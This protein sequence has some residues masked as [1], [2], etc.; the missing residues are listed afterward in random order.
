MIG[1][2]GALAVSNETAAQIGRDVLADGGNAVDAAVAVSFALGVVE[3]FHSGLG[4]GGF[5]VYFDAPSARVSALDL[6]GVAPAAA[7]ESMFVR[8]GAY[9]ADRAVIGHHSVVVPG[10]VAGLDLAHRR[11]GSRP[12]AELVE[13]AAR[14]AERGVAVTPIMAYKC[15]NDTTRRAL[16]AHPEGARLYLRDGRVPP[17]GTLLRNPDLAASCRLIGRQGADAF[18]RGEIASAIVAD[19]RRHDGPITADDLARYRPRDLPPLRGRYRD[20]ELFAMPPPS[21]GGTLVLQALGILEGFD[22]TA[23][24]RQAPETAHLLAETLKLAF[25]DRDYYLGD[26]DF[27]DPP[28]AG[29]L[30][31]R[32]LAARRSLIQPDRA[33]AAVGHGQPESAQTTSFSI[34]DRHGNLLALT[35][36]IGMNL[37]S[38]VVPPGTGIVLNHTM[39]D[40]SPGP[41][42]PTPFGWGA[43]SSRANAIA[44]GKA[45]ASSQAPTLVFRAGRPWFAV[46]AAG[47]SR[48]PTAVLQV[49]INAVDYDD[50]LQQAITA[51]RLH[52]QG[53]D[54]E[55]ERGWF[56]QVAEP[57]RRL[58]HR[59]SSPEDYHAALPCWAQAAGRTA[60]GY[61]AGADPRADGLALGLER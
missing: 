11:W 37:A 36:T 32:Y 10:L 40:F 1:S 29:L 24:H 23:H 42:L 45:P 30:S 14:L 21:A 55:I 54:L 2:A 16:A 34:A 50:D 51:P 38:G 58:G 56:E 4:G 52:E 18:Y 46:G 8:D 25:A 41:G 39:S 48:I 59:V 28:L 53:E 17:A 26:P 49:I 20:C 61:Q 44:P 47:G 27:V 9:Q 57:L 7:S 5:L 31:E 15:D 60:D 33:L 43:Y 3:P 6:R 35:Q 12:L 13:P 22:L 19:M